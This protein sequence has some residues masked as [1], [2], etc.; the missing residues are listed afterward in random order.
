MSN[1]HEESVHH[2]EHAEVTGLPA[3]V[4]LDEQEAENLAVWH[5]ENIGADVV[6]R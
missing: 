4:P 1:P 5:A 6:D 3:P 2:L